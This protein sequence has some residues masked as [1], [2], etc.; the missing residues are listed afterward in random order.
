M[1]RFWPWLRI[2]G[3]LGILAVLVWR[4][5]TS[6]FLDGLRE[7]DAAGVAAALAIGFTT[8]VF[9]A[10]RWRL[11]ARRLSLELPVWSAVGEYYRA[12]FLNGV[13]P[14]GV[15]G[16]VDRA[17]QHGRASGDVPRG[18]RAV[19]LERTAG[20]IV[21]IGAS[22]AVVLSTPSVVPRP[23][24]KIV[25][26]AGIVVVMLA[27]AAV[28]TGMTAGKRWSHSGSKWRR[29]F[30]VTLA[31][32]RLGLL[33]KETWP[34]VSLLSMAT[35]AGHLALFVVAARAAG[36]TAPIGELLPLMILALLAMGLPL[37]IGGWG[38][39]EGVCALLFG[40]AGLGSAQGVTVAVV[41]GVLALVASLPGAA[42][43]LA[44]SFETHR[45]D[46]SAAP[47]IAARVVRTPVRTGETR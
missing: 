40:A 17:V 4:L 44:R 1:K 28:V 15:L 13:L 16:D 43:L 7:V 35:L 23:I 34:G 18:V 26:V 37:N 24:D 38:P 11:V 3:A 39:R 32:V 8:T 6:A 12:L 42:V 25:M 33:T 10:W 9:S 20:Q 30:A 31:D 45:I 2:L 27:L 21:L 29:G 46:T 36:V 5:G 19:V 14:A 22:V 41:Y 47:R